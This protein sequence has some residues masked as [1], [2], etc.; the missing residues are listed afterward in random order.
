MSLQCEGWWDCFL[1]VNAWGSPVSGWVGRMGPHAGLHPIGGW[2][3]QREFCELRK[4]GT[5]QG[6]V[7]DDLQIAPH[8]RHISAN[9]YS[10]SEMYLL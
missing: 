2:L 6:A 10:S 1:Q 8:T 5:R 3:G 9:I 4:N 7:C